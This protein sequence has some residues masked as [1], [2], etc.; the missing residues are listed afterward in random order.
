MKRDRL[1][2]LRKRLGLRPVV[3]LLDTLKGVHMFLQQNQQLKFQKFRD[4]EKV[5][6]LR[7][8]RWIF[9]KLTDSMTIVLVSQF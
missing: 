3:Q 9:S 8:F 5:L 6:N 1:L 7:L 2:I 4:R